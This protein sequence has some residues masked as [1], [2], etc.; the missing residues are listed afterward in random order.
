MKHI[1]KDLEQHLLPLTMG[2]TRICQ[3]LCMKRQ[4]DPCGAKEN[5]RTSHQGR[6]FV[7]GLVWDREL[8]K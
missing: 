1:N 8:G 2:N 3:R 7:Q 4:M 5:E 6:R